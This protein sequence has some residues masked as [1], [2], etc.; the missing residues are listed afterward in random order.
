MTDLGMMLLVAALFFALMVALYIIGMELN[1]REFKE[2]VY[3][4][5]VTFKGRGSLISI[6]FE[7]GANYYPSYDSPS[8][9]GTLVYRFDRPVDPYSIHAMFLSDG[10]ITCD[11]RNVRITIVKKPRYAE[12]KPLTFLRRRGGRARSRR[13]A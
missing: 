3:T 9:D 11:D 12:C 5:Q 10:D 1:L 7:G 6:E 4:R 8:F 2:R 13:R